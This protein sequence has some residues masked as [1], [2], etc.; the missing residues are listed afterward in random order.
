MQERQETKKPQGNIFS[1]YLL[2]IGF[3]CFVL[4][5]FLSYQLTHTIAQTQFST[6][7]EANSNP[8]ESWMTIRY[9]S[10]TY[11]VPE[12]IFVQKLSLTENQAQRMPL[13]KIA[14]QKNITTETL[15][16]EVKRI[17][18]EFMSDPNK[19]VKTL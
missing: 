12:Q 15:I 16:T 11:H 10:H 4:A 18:M 9:I 14:R 1:R 3:I 6:P 19:H 8:I 13:E 7:R 2:F 5:A 17:L